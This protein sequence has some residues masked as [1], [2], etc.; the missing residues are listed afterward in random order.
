VPS[1]LDELK[2]AYVAF[3]IKTVAKNDIAKGAY[4][5]TADQYAVLSRAGISPVSSD[6]KREIP[7]R[8]VGTNTI[9]PTSYYNALRATP[10]RAPEARMGR[11]LVN[12]LA[13]GDEL[14][15]ATDGTTVFAQKLHA[16]DKIALPPEQ[17]ATAV[18]RVYQQLDPKR[19]LARA[20]QASG[21]PATAPVTVSQFVRDPA[22]KALTI[23]RCGGKCEVPGCGWIGFKKD[24]GT[25]YIQVHH[26][27]PLGDGGDDTILNTIGICP[28][29]HALAHYGPGRAAFAARLLKVVAAAQAAF[30]AALKAA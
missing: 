12:W 9:L 25:L 18:E 7:I 28:N 21:R 11:G 2:R 8:V 27:K 22:V 14:L 3:A 19:L 17:L 13:A 5:I 16:H 20:K 10:G 6:Q 24:D 29:C 26:V 4:Y 15:L 30:E 23:Q 1:I